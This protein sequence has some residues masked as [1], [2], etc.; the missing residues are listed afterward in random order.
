MFMEKNLV[1]TL[2]SLMIA[3]LTAC[4]SAPRKNKNAAEVAGASPDSRVDIS[5]VL[6]QS[7]YQIHFESNADLALGRSLVDHET[8]K[9]TQLPPEKY[10]KYLQQVSDFVAAPHRTPA[11]ATTCHS[12]FTVNVKVG[13]SEHTIS[14]CRTSEEKDFSQMVQDSEFLLCSKKR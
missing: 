3:A 7:F 11:E 2:L 5:Y 12:P 1:K 14:S 9:D 6:G 8:V 10:A 4:S 13:K